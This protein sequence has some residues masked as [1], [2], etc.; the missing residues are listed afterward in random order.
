MLFENII[1]FNAQCKHMDGLQQWMTCNQI[2]RGR[3]RSRLRGQPALCLLYNLITCTAC[4]YLC[5]V[6]NCLFLFALPWATLAQVLRSQPDSLLMDR[7]IEGVG[8]RLFWWAAIGVNWAGSNAQCVHWLI[9][10]GYI[11]KDHQKYLKERHFSLSYQPRGKLRKFNICESRTLNSRLM[12]QMGRYLGILYGS[13][14]YT[15]PSYFLTTAPRSD[16]S[17]VNR[18]GMVN[19]PIRAGKYNDMALWVCCVIFFAVDVHK[20][21]RQFQNKFDQWHMLRGVFHH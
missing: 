4:S 3:R 17:T 13:Y 2:C 5:L 12:P 20:T 6:W 7:C 18:G 9:A 11:L 19:L 15:V 1:C 14:L 21:L 16:Q 8:A 10:P